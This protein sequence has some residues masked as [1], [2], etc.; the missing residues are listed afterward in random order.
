MDGKPLRDHLGNLAK[1]GDAMALA[2]LSAV[3]PLPTGCMALWRDF[4]ALHSNRGSN[5][6]GPERIGFGEIDAYQ[7]L[8]GMRFAGWEL[9]AIRRADAAYIA[10]Y[11]SQAKEAAR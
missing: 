10:E 11:A 3:P 7:R 9:E 6:F 4:M 8:H 5:G 2:T 1:R